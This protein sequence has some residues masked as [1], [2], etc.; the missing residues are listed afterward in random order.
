MDQAQRSLILFAQFPQKLHR[1]LCTKG[2]MIVIGKA[3]IGRQIV[4][5]AAHGCRMEGLCAITRHETRWGDEEPTEIMGVRF[6]IT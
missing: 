2:S 6:T 4:Q 5:L 3:F 1:P